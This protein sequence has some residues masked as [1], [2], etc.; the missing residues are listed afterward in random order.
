MLRLIPFLPFAGFLLNTTFGRAHERSFHRSL[1]VDDEFRHA[2]QRPFEMVIRAVALA[3][4]RRYSALTGRVEEIAAMTD[5]GHAVSL[6]AS[7]IPG[8]MPLQWHFYERL[9]TA[10]WLPHLVRQ[11]LTAAPQS[12]ST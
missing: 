2:F 7:E 6:F 8:A 5:K 12:E 4:Q 3:L 10:D 1:A 11:N 9:Q